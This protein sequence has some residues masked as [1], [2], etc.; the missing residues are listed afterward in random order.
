[1][2]E[3]VYDVIGFKVRL[4]DII[5]ADETGEPDPNGWTKNTQI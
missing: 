5:Y 1:M 4:E 3:W 2:M